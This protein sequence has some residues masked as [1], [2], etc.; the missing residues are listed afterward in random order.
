MTANPS[1]PSLEAEE[2]AARS[3]LATYKARLY[4]APPPSPMVAQRR[5]ARLQRQWELASTRLNHARK[6][7]RS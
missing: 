7:H 1:L 6:A 4:A 2:R 5:L 3:R